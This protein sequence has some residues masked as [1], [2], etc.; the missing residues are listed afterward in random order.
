[1][2]TVTCTSDMMSSLQVGSSSAGE[3]HGRHN[4]R[5]GRNAELEGLRPG[6]P[7]ARGLVPSGMSTA[8]TSNLL[9]RIG[10]WDKRWVGSF[11]LQR[12]RQ[13]FD[14]LPLDF[15]SDELSSANFAGV[16]VTG[17]CISLWAAL[18]DVHELHPNEIAERAPL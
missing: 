8:S 10:E 2:V 13:S 1:M 6:V 7:V 18:G 4:G 5:P 16:A 11:C 14:L 3:I 15:K 9:Y 12:E 17:H